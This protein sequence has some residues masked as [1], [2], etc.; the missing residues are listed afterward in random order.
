MG[1][2]VLFHL[3]S[4]DA[5]WTACVLVLLS[6]SLVARWRKRWTLTIAWVLVPM[7]GL[8]FVGSGSPQPMWLTL[9]LMVSLPVWLV[10]EGLG[11]LSGRTI[12]IIRFIPLGLVAVL[13]LLEQPW[14]VNPR[15]ANPRERRLYVVADSIS[16][17]LGTQGVVTWPNL[18]RQ[19][20][21]IDVT[22]LARAGAT[23]ESALKDLGG[24]SLGAGL[25]LV[26]IGGNDMIGGWDPEGFARAL[27]ALLLR[28]KQASDSVVMLELPV[29]PG[30]TAYARA[31]RDIAT[32]HGVVLIPKRQ[33]A[34]ILTREGNTL[35]GLHLSA[36]GQREMAEWIWTYV[37]SP[38][39]MPQ[40]P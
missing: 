17:G 12:R 23:A 37:R 13:I 10:C 29:L 6:I 4:G 31:Q 32:R 27:D 26:E 39:G 19:E 35:D 16:A 30:Q 33:F 22:D 25:I 38:L 18:L 3:A 2:W 9:M 1:Q 24:K 21:G 20:H 36:Q 11:R 5:L 34:V 8:A 7:G 14:H 15:I 40:K 28:L